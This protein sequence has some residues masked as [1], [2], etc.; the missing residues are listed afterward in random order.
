[1]LINKYKQIYS[2]LFL[3]VVLL[4]QIRKWKL[5]EFLN[6]IFAYIICIL[7][8]FCRL[9]VIVAVVFYPVFRLAF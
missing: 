4:L 2:L 1:M 3:I 7:G 6:H 8:Y 9:G 5:L